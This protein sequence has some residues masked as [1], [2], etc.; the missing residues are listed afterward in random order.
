AAAVPGT[1]RG[2]RSNLSGSHPFGQLAD[3]ATRILQLAL[4]LWCLA[5][6]GLDAARSERLRLVGAHEPARPGVG[7]CERHVQPGDRIEVE[8][9]A[10]SEHVQGDLKAV[11]LSP[12]RDRVGAPAAL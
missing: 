1:G 7:A 11:V 12:A 9:L 5:N 2:T 6:V 4:E 8:Q 10:C 3:P